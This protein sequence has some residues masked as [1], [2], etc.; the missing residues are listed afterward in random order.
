MNRDLKLGLSFGILCSGLLAAFCLKNEPDLTTGLPKLEN[1]EQLDRQIADRQVTPYLDGLD[2]FPSGPSISRVAPQADAGEWSSLG[3]SIVRTPRP[4]DVTLGSPVSFG[5]F[6]SDG[7]SFGR[8]PDPIRYE[9]LPTLEP[10]GSDAP[11]PRRDR[12][13]PTDFGSHPADFDLAPSAPRPI[14]DPRA[15][16][17]PTLPTTHVVMPGE[18]LSG[19][20]LKHYS[21]SSYY[22]KIFEANRHLLRDPDSVR[23]GMRLLIPA[24]DKTSQ[25]PRFEKIET[26]D[27]GRATGPTAVDPISNPQR[28]DLPASGPSDRRMGH[29]A[30]PSPIQ[31]AVR[32]TTTSKP[33]SASKLFRPVSR[34]PF[35]SSHKIENREAAAKS[36][37]IERPRTTVIDSTNI[38]EPGK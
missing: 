26:F 35:V 36:Q 32:D 33:A 3:S 13:A 5:Q 6:V 34:P 8:V 25:L 15:V 18:T 17:G 19:I 29:H 30:P 16:R 37:P 23:V 14:K 2:E 11:K 24:V 9:S 27:S 31:V 20:A 21:D 10:I 4:T 7:P 12:M 1:P 28:A 38:K 22:G